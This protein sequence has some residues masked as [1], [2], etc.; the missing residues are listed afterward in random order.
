[1]IFWRIWFLLSDCKSRWS[2]CRSAKG[3]QKQSQK[4]G[5]TAAAKRRPWIN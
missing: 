4:P 1:M 2:E 5:P 3:K